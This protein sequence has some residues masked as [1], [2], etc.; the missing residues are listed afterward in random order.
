MAMLARKH[1]LSPPITGL[2]L[3][4]PAVT[5]NRAVPPEYAPL[6]SYVQNAEAP[7]LGQDA[8]DLFMSNYTPDVHSP[9]YNVLGDLSRTG[10]WSGLPARVF[11]QVAG[12]DPLRDEALIFERELR[13]KA[14]VETKLEVYK[15][16]PHSFYTALPTLKSSKR[17]VDDTT[18]GVG[19]LLGKEY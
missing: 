13:T 7:I 18:R 14:G 4:I 1:A 5:D 19:W 17:F 10:D 9:L 6:H 12:M 8:V 2:C 15:G 16:L 11:F 3:L